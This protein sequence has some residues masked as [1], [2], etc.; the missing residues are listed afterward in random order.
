MKELKNLVLF[1]LAL[2]ITIPL[3][4]CGLFWNLAK[5]IYHVYKGKFWKILSNWFV[6]WFKLLYQI[7]VVIGY[8]AY[9]LA[10]SLD[11]LWNA[12]SGEFIEDC[13]TA[14]EET[15]FGKGDTTVS[16]STGELDFDGNLNKTG[17]YFSK[18]LDFI[19]VEKDHALNAYKRR[20]NRL[21]E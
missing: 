3:L 12:F 10:M 2:I 21:K 11:L 8:L 16:E 1:G 4:F 19:F 6:Y 17:R 18:F 5:P 9:H 20:I 7:Y 14:Q 15:L 13:I